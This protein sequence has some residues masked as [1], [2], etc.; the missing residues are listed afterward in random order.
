MDYRQQRFLTDDE[1]RSFMVEQAS[2]EKASIRQAVDA[3]RIYVV[4]GSGV[5]RVHLWDCSSLREQIDRDRAWSFWLHGDPE[6]F[7]KEVAHGDGG[8]RM[9]LL[10]DRAAIEALSTYVTCQICSPTL[11]HTKK[12]RGERTAKLTSLSARHIG[13]SLAALDGAPLGQLQ[14]IV[15]TVDAGGSKVRVD[16]TTHSFTDDDRPSVFVAPIAP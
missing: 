11:G 3:D 8:P 5:R 14:R 12:S 7:R 16:T 4:A 15:T 2:A 10:L 13:R 6:N 1:L 9:P